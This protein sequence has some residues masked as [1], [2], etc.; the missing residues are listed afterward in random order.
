M[1]GFFKGK[2]EKKAQRHK[3]TKAQS[4]KRICWISAIILFSL[5]IITLLKT[6]G[7]AP[8]AAGC[9]F[10][11]TEN[12]KNAENQQVITNIIKFLSLPPKKDGRS[13]IPAAHPDFINHGLTRISTDYNKEGWLD[14]LIDKI[15]FVESSGRLNPPDGDGGRAVGP[16]Q[17]HKCVVDDVNYFY[18][19]NYKYEDRRDI[20]KSREIAK[21]YITM[22][23]EKHRE[24]IAALIFHYGPSAWKQDVDG[25]W[26]KIRDENTARMAVLR[27]RRE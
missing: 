4:V 10:F 17:L 6:A 18:K 25:Y 27:K 14:E 2:I 5:S 24:Q 8:P 13:F 21:L 3:G 9:D 15:H 7:G 12:T 23:M 26:K 20:D 1:N 19:T 22:W 11:T 16:M